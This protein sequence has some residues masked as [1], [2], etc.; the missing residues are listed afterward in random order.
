MASLAVSLVPALVL[1]VIT[2]LDWVVPWQL[3]GLTL[4]TGLARAFEIPETLIS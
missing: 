3:V 4:I 1:A 2:I